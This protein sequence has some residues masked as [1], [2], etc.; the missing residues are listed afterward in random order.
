MVA[1]VAVIGSWLSNRGRG[2]VGGGVGCPMGVGAVVVVV[3]AAV[4]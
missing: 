4:I 1:V 2:S 3:V